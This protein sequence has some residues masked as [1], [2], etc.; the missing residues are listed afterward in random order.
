MAI[1]SRVL[2]SFSTA[3]RRAAALAALIPILAL[4]APPQLRGQE[5]PPS[6]G[7]DSTTLA[8]ADSL[9]AAMRPSR[10]RNRHG[11][12]AADILSVPFKIVAWPINFVLVRLPAVAIGELSVPR[13]PGFFVRTLSDLN[14]AGVHPGLRSSIGPRSGPAAAVRVDP[15][16]PVEIEAAF[17]M[18]ASQR[19][20]VGGRVKEPDFRLEAGA[21]WQ[22]D[23]SVAFYGIGSDTPERQTLYRR[24]RFEVGA[25]AWHR[26][27]PLWVEAD[28][29]YENNLIGEPVWAANR[30]A[31]VEEFAPA[32]VFGLDRRLRYV[33]LG[34]GAGLDFTRRVGFQDRG[35]RLYA[36][37]TRYEGVEGTNSFHQL[38]FRAEGL[39]PLNRRQLLALMARTDL[40]R[41]DSGRIPFYYLAALGGEE[42][43]LG[44]PDTRFTDNDMLSLAAEWRYE[45]WR[46]IHNKTRLESFVYFGRGA[47]APRLG[48]IDSED[49]HTSYAFGFRAAQ[50]EDLLGLIYLGFSAEGVQFGAAGEWSP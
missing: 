10:P 13:P 48:E 17:S 38:N 40:T 15:L 47:V 37:G 36:H 43:A 1:S 3:F 41:E 5:A 45:V 6:V 26:R 25:S 46:D 32:E 34:L 21:A 2:T 19:Y 12:D 8:R 11:T 14:R 28:A 44:F 7:P 18:R 24:D 49:W 33:R 30:P 20:W 23:A 31:T 22:R 16:S 50:R 29:A 9:R 4:V 35:V 39:A 42:T 27:D